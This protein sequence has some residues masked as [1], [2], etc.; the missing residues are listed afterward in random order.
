MNG[1]TAADQRP[2]GVVDSV[3]AFGTNLG[4]LAT[5]QLRLAAC[6]ARESLKQL[7]PTLVLGA[8]G[9]IV[10]PSSVVVALVGAAYWIAS[11]SSWTLPQA[12]LLVAGTGIILSALALL[13]AIRLSR[14]CF[15]SF[16]RS[17]EELQRNIA[18]IRTVAKYSGR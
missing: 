9:L 11:S 15:T 4:S 17:S 8:F 18:W 5:L 10:C 6:D 13:I 14:G 12:F 7:A 16:R 3:N 1:S 2:S